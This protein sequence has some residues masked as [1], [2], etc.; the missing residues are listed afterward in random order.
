MWY[1]IIYVDIKKKIISSY[2]TSD[3]RYLDAKYDDVSLPKD[4]AYRNRDFLKSL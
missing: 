4:V 3:M 2:N 1:V